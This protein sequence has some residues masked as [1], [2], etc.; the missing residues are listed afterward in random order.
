[1]TP[2][3]VIV[4]C[5]LKLDTNVHHMPGNQAFASRI[6]CFR[7]LHLSFDAH[8]AFLEAWGAALIIVLLIR[9]SWFTLVTQASRLC[10]RDVNA[11]A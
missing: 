2:H 9:R 11:D 7:G 1:M 6:A 10:I 4:P 8:I 3:L 5:F